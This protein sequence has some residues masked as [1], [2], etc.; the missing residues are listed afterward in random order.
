MCWVNRDIGAVVKTVAILKPATANWDAIY[1]LKIPNKLNPSFFI[2]P[3]LNV[4]GHPPL[5][6][7]LMQC[8]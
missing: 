6:Q 4:S 5:A 8:I 2:I 3:P 7:S 1:L